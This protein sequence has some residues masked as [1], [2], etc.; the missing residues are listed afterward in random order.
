[1]QQEAPKLPRNGFASATVTSLGAPTRSNRPK[2]MFPWSKTRYC[3]G[4]QEQANPF[5]SLT[6][7]WGNRR[8]GR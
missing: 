2:S 3:A 7:V 5:F 8:K 6:N 4:F 1:M